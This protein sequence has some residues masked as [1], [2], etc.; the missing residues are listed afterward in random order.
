M[1]LNLAKKLTEIISGL[2]K[3]TIRKKSQDNSSKYDKTSEINI[4]ELNKK[5]VA[6]FFKKISLKLS[7]INFNSNFTEVVFDPQNRYKVQKLFIIGFYMVSA[8]FSGKLISSFFPKADPPEY[9]VRVVPIDENQDDFHKK[10]DQ[11]RIA[12]L[13]NATIYKDDGGEGTKP[14]TPQVNILNIICLNSKVNSSLPLRLVNT[15]VLQDSVKSIA[16][17]Q[18]RSSKDPFIYR[19][20]DKIEQLAEVSKIK[21]TK[22]ILKNL[23]TGRCEFINLK[24]LFERNNFANM[25]VLPPNSMRTAPTKME[26][27]DRDG[28]KFKIS[29]KLINEKLKD[30]G[31]VLSEAKAIK[32]TNPDGTL[33]FRIVDI[34]PGSI[35]SHLDIQNLDEITEINGEKIKNVNEIMN[36]FGTIRNVDKL[37]ITLLRQGET[38]NLNYEI[39]K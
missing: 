35:Y 19:E 16:S 18:V 34:V 26:G 30:L 22:V 6:D 32:V 4:S 17:V 25:S 8:Y 10:I 27:I 11:I 29:R 23:E 13:F 1:K 39:Q 3:I 31:S 12:N 33:A 38:K 21:K 14:K 28:N 36:L 20:G 5:P 15:V 37:N 2:K 7:E 9:S 24:D